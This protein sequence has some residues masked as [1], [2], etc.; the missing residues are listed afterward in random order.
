MPP[1]MIPTREKYLEL[2][3]RYS[4]EWSTHFGQGMRVKNIKAV[5]NM[6]TSFFIMQVPFLLYWTLPRFQ[7]SPFHSRISQLIE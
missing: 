5:K 1:T 7:S 6:Q 2:F 4:C 3:V